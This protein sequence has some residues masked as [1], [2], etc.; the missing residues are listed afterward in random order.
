MHSNTAIIIGA[1]GLIG[2][3]LL[4][5]LLESDDYEEVRVLTRRKIDSE[6]HKLKQFVIDFS[7]LEKHENLIQ[8]ADIYCCLGITLKKAGSKE[9]AYKVEVT[10]P[11]KIAQIAFKNN[12]KHFLLVSSIG[13]SPKSNNYYLRGKSDIEQKIQ[14]I[15]FRSISIFR[16]SLLLG[17]RKEIRIGEDIGKVFSIA[18]APFIP[19]K[20]KAIKAQ[21]VAKY[22]YLTAKKKKVGVSI[23]ES[24]QIRRIE[25]KTFDMKTFEEKTYYKDF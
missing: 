16:P 7:N 14:K 22:M 3:Y 19:A 15:P 5:F 24:N 11:E 9:N 12:A 18:F 21:T 2:N 17:P 25:R 13:A 20:Y 23:Y 4:N 6:H 1:T 8:G 10:Y